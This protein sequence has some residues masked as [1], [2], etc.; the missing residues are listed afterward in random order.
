MDYEILTEKV[1]EEVMKRLS[2]KQ[3]KALIIFTGSSAGYDESLNQV[4][5]L[6]ERGWEIEVIVNR[7]SEGIFTKEKFNSD[8]QGMTLYFESRYPVDKDM[9][10]GV[11]IILI[12]VL[13]VNFAA[14]MALGISDTPVSALVAYGLINGIPIMGVNKACLPE[15]RIR[16]DCRNKK[17]PGAYYKMIHG[18]LSR[19]EEFGVRMV[20]IEKLSEEAESQCMKIDKS[21]IE[22][23]RNATC[24]VIS[25]EYIMDMNKKGLSQI[26]VSRK[27]IITA[28]ARE[29]ANELGVEIICI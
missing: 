10:D 24:D 6:V 7:C 23:H 2:T 19:L 14:K 27:T 8:F 12:P 29:T 21:E 28:L 3:S 26:A 9:L 18:Y 16:K 15:N 1:I 25:K 4:K 17:K 22:N 13:T 11:D 5:L 20:S